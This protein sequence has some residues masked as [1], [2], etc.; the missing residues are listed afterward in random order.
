MTSGK[1][2]QAR[3]PYARYWDKYVERFFPRI[4]ARA[5]AQYEWPG[6]EWGGPEVWEGI[7]RQLLVPAGVQNWQRAVEIGPGSGKYTLQ[8]LTDSQTVVRAYDVSAQFLKVCETR[9]EEFV[10]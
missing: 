1:N 3:N 9:C 10:N 4:N 5:G 2:E 8:V 6:D 7:H